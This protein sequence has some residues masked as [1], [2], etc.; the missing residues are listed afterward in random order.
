[1]LFHLS[2]Y[3]GSNI[4]LWFIKV[5]LEC[6]PL[7]EVVKSSR[8]IWAYRG[9]SGWKRIGELEKSL[10]ASRSSFSYRC[11]CCH[12]HTGRGRHNPHCNLCPLHLRLCCASS[13]NI[14]DHCHPMP[15][16]HSGI[17]GMKIIRNLHYTFLI[18]SSFLLLKSSLYPSAHP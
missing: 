2:I 13:H 17:Q 15:M 3:L 12:S 14:V 9:Q 5:C 11:K 7:I 1:M 18:Q 6:S 8:S 10:W 4:I 16:W